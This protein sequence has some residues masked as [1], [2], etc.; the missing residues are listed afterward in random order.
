MRKLFILCALLLL[1]FAGNNIKAQNPFKEY[2]YDPGVLTLSNGKYNEFFKYDT[3]VQIG[4]IFFNTITE[5]VVAYIEPD[6]IADEVAYEPEVVS[7]WL[8]PDPLAEKYVEWSP[9]NYTYNNPVLFI[10][11]N[12]MEGVVVTGGE[13]DSEK[14]Y[15]YN[16]VETSINQ[17]QKLVDAGGDEPITW[18]VMNVGYS[19]SDIEKF[20]EIADKMG[21]NLQLVGSAE[22][23]TNYLN[24]KDVGS[25]EL[26]EAREG[27]QVTSLAVFGH[28]F[29]GSAEFG[30]G[31]GDAAQEKFSW[32]MNEASNLN[33]GAF[34]NAQIDFYTCNAGTDVNSTGFSGNSL[35]R[36]VA[37]TTNSTT[38]GYWGRTDYAT[39]NRGQSFSNKLNRFFNGFN[40]RGSLYLPTPGRKGRTKIRSTRVKLV[41]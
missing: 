10:D 15:K 9:Y 5:K 19:D 30:Y 16:F 6:T 8:A 18:A 7:R 13:Y 4:T 20:Q 38:T 14:R 2:G 36:T 1:M 11:P 27:D 41:R 23:L 34:N 24:S 17:L 39:M 32:G 37:N 21:V 3:I 26:S 35:I 22:E 31:Q 25:S 33:A 28:G 29:A 12:G 40:T